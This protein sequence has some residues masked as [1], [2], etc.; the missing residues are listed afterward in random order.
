MFAGREYPCKETISAMELALDL[1]FEGVQNNAKRVGLRNASP[2]RSPA[3]PSQS[4]RRQWQRRR[5]Y[6]QA[7]FGSKEA[8]EISWIDETQ[9]AVRPPIETPDELIF[10]LCV[11]CGYGRSHEAEFG[12]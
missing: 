5:T 2:R 4:R 1:D 10:P 7:V 9:F 11:F 3:A 8:H 6:Q 12:E